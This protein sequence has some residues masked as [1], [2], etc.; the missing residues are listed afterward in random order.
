MNTQE[1][2]AEWVRR[3][4]SGE[5]KQAKFVLGRTF[6]S[7]CC[8]GVACDIAVEAGIISK[9]IQ[10][11]IFDSRMAYDGE[12]KLLPSAVK[13]FFGL[14]RPD[15]GY[16]VNMMNSLSADNDNGKTFKEIADIIQSNPPGLFVE[17]A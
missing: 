3:L 10:Q 8:L 5:I 4:R 14:A 7:R 9:E 17:N 6:G 13:H 15:G 2:R 11:G 12:D 16:G 1:A